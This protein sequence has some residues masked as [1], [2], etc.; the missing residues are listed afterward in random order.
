MLVFNPYLNK[1]IIIYIL[2][3]AVVCGGSFVKTDDKWK[4]IQ[5]SGVVPKYKESLNAVSA[6][7]PRLHRHISFSRA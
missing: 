1:I 2:K 3:I 4:F 7:I 6:V 5:N